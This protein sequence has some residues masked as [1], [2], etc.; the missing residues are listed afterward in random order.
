MDNR[1]ANPQ[2]P[3]PPRTR[4]TDLR[5][6]IQDATINYYLAGFHYKK[7]RQMLETFP[8]FATVDESKYSAENLEKTCRSMQTRNRDNEN[9][10]NPWLQTVMASTSPFQVRRGANTDFAEQFPEQASQIREEAEFIEMGT[11][12]SRWREEA[13]LLKRSPFYDFKM[14]ADAISK[15]LDE[16]QRQLVKED[17]EPERKSGKPKVS[18]APARA[19]IERAKSLSSK[20]SPEC[21][22][23]RG[24][25]SRPTSR[26]SSPGGGQAK[27]QKIPHPG[28]RPALKLTTRGVSLTRPEGTATPGRFQYLDPDGFFSPRPKSE[29]PPRERR[30]A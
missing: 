29:S 17:L 24:R 19:L 5:V 21:S 4:P 11:W 18:F 25:N 16:Y 27:P 1:P 9:I 7:I 26:P 10:F 12:R 28:S 15:S 23:K 20:K 8:N 22:P 6:I 2:E 30:T 3:P 13:A 14:K